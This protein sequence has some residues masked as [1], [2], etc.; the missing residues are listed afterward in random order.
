MTTTVT[1]TAKC[2]PE[3]TE[4]VI[5]KTVG[6]KVEYEKTIQDNDSFS[7]YVYGAQVIQVTEVAKK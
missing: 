4:V 3:T 5:T 2:N 1:V 7:D 6:T